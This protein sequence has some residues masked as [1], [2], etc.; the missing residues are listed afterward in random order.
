MICNIV[1]D[2]KMD[3]EQFLLL[4]ECVYVHIRGGCDIC[5]ILNLDVLNSLWYI[6]FL[7]NKMFTQKQ[8]LCKY[9]KSTTIFLTYLSIFAFVT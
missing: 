1:T 7:F 6:S 2:S 9:H 4:L 3:Y 8:Y 5:I